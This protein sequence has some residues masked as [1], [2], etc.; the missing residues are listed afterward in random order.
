MW[1]DI[2]KEDGDKL[3]NERVYDSFIKALERIFD[4]VIEPPKPSH[5]ASLVEIEQR[6]DDTELTA[7]IV[8]NTNRISF[9]WDHW[10][11]DITKGWRWAG[12]KEGY[13][14][15]KQELIDNLKVLDRKLMLYLTKPDMGWKVGQPTPRW[16]TYPRMGEII[17]DVMGWK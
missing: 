2:L 1:F 6:Y 10:N 8:L 9:N 12:S 11:T 7:Y 4:T 16:N 17:E 5:G 13:F 14:K 15:N 3:W